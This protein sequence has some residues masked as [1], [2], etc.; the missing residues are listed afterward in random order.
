MHSA[1]FRSIQFF[2]NE[3]GIIQSHKHLIPT[4]SLGTL[5]VISI[6]LQVEHDL[7]GISTARTGLEGFFHA[8]LSKVIPVSYERLHIYFPSSQKFNAE[9]PCIS[10]SE[11]AYDIHLPMTKKNSD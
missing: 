3:G 1:P 11:N 10:I 4:L 2:F 5:P 8:R 7:D 6:Q 9:W